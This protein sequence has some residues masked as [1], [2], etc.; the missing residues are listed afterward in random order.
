MISIKRLVI[1]YFAVFFACCVAFFLWYEEKNDIK[2]EVIEH[3]LELFDLSRRAGQLSMLVADYYL[4]GSER[5]LLQ[6]QRVVSDLNSRLV[7]FEAHPMDLQPEIREL[8]N[9][10]RQL[11]NQI[12]LLKSAQTDQAKHWSLVN[13]IALNQDLVEAMQAMAT[14]LEHWSQLQESAISRAQFVALIG[15]VA[16][17]IVLAVFLLL[18]FLSPMSKLEGELQRI[19]KGDLSPANASSEI[20]EWQSL[21]SQFDRMREELR[22]LVVNRKELEKEVEQ[23]RFAELANQRLANTDSLTG[24]PNRRFFYE[25]LSNE[26][27]Q[28]QRYE[29]RFFLLFIDFDNFKQVND[30]LGHSAGDMLLS[31]IA[32][33]L[34]A[35]G[36][37]AAQIARIGG[38]E[39]AVILS[40]DEEAKA[41][42]FAQHIKQIIGTPIE[43][44]HQSI[45]ISSSLG[46]AHYP[47]DS[48][49]LEGLVSR[50]DTAMYFAKNNPGSTRGVAVYASMMGATTREQFQLVDEV[51]RAIRNDGFEVWLQPQFK[52]ETREVTGFE[53]LIRCQSKQGD[54]LP[55]SR[56]VPYLESS[57]EIVPVGL[58]LV[59]NVLALQLKLRQLGLE[60]PISLNVSAVQLER[61]A[62][63]DELWE[64]VTLYKLAPSDLPLELTE[65]AVFKN[66]DVIIG[67]LNRLHQR[68]FELHLDDFGTGN[69]SLDLIRKVP[70]S[71]LK[72]DQTFVRGALDDPAC[73]AI[74][75]ATVALAKGLGIELIMEGIETPAHLSLAHARQVEYGQGYLMAKPMPEQA[76]FSWLEDASFFDRNAVS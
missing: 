9:L 38:D 32:K 36:D 30:S 1:G 61:E 53:A 48:E 26:L 29:K 59:E 49:G 3:Q 73:V 64:L 10:V 31:T 47:Q 22:Q 16:L 57:G 67:N 76:L 13:L 51:N 11:N 41:V 35:D 69:A 23:R 40:C 39:F 56:F 43:Y 75:D 44:Q 65:T 58:Q 50:A 5:A 8:S 2:Q 20:S 45:S 62:F 27:A 71:A 68:G 17:F 37:A 12:S 63:V 54:Y 74:I 7:Q 70:F 60:V 42:A 33:R 24:L 21:F 72:I 25:M 6:W 15:S 28:A 4:S 55:P 19:G 66:E 52:V 18:Y 46:I 34:R 14:K